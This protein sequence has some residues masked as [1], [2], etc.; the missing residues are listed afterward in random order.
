[1]KKRVIALLLAATMAFALTA[2]GSSSTTE[3]TTDTTDASAAEEAAEDTAEDETSAEAEAE[4][5]D[6]S[7]LYEEAV[8]Q[9]YVIG[10]DTTFAPF[11]FEN[12]EGEHT[13]IDIELFEAIADEMGFTIEWDILGFSASVAALEAGQVDGVMAGM[14]ITDERMEKYDFSDSYYDCSIA[15]A[16]ASDSEIE[17]LDDLAGSTVVAKTGTTG[18]QYAEELAEEYDLELLYAEESSVMYQYVASGQAVACF[19]DYPIVQYEIARGNVD[20]KVINT[21]EYS[22]P[23]GMAVLSGNYPELVAAFNEGFARLQEDG[24]YDEILAHYFE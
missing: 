7:A 10:T 14:S 19:E 23:T 22:Y 11:E 1:M 8:G 16:V 18:S 12:D 2:C 5:S 15:V 4:E 17:S 24:T 20:C 9:T 13:G 6:A 3:E 21:S